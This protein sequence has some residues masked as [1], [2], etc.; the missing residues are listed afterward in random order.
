MLRLTLSIQAKRDAVD[1]RTVKEVPRF[2]QGT[3][4]ELQRQHTRRGP[5]RGQVALRFADRTCIVS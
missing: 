1:A 2:A 3:G 5:V 4:W